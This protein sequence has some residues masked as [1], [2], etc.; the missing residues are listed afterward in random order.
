MLR[1]IPTTNTAGPALTEALWHLNAA[2]GQGETTGFGSIITALDG[3]KWLEIDEHA[4]VL[5]HPEAVLDGI[6]DVLQPWI[7][8]G[9]LPADTNTAL[10]ALMESKRGETLVVYDAFPQLFKDQSK[11]RQ[12]LINE[13]KLPDP[14]A[15]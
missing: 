10:S 4:E 9:S 14:T 2:P 12:D 1:Y 5:V 8:E 7:D 6:T 15:L 13:G 3:S 11:S